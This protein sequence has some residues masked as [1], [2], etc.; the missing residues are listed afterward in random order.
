ML[1]VQS[2]IAYAALSQRSSLSSR[3]GFCGMMFSFGKLDAEPSSDA[4]QARQA[5]A[6]WDAPI[7]DVSPADSALRFRS[8]VRD[9]T[10]LNPFSEIKYQR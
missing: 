6:Q 1:P 2:Y 8:S 10:H 4:I 3:R 9:R 7:P 5:M